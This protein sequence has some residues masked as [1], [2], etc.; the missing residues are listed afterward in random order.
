MDTI[1]NNVKNFATQLHDMLSW[2]YLDLLQQAFKEIEEFVDKALFYDEKHKQEISKRS[3]VSK[4]AVDSWLNVFEK[5]LTVFHSNDLD[6]RIINHFFESLGLYIDDFIVNT[7]MTQTVNTGRCLH[8]KMTLSF[9][10]GW[11][12]DKGVKAA[13]YS[14]CFHSFI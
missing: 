7:M 10:E 1:Q 2:A 11:L 13:R 5:Y 12:F 8:I 6:L 3:S 9:L 14:P 4:R